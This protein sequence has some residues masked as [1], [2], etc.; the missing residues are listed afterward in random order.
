MGTY[1]VG[2]IVLG[3]VGL[4]IRKIYQDKKAG[5]GC[6]SCESCGCGGCGCSSDNSNCSN[7]S[8]NS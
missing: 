4:A 6:G 3:I 2:A 5:K 7:G 8:H 1:I